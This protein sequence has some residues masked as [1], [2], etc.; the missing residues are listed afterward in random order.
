MLPISKSRGSAML[1]AL[2][3]MLVLTIAAA[4]VLR[5]ANARFRSTVQDASWQESIYSAEAGVDIAVAALRDNT[6]TGWQDGSGASATGAPPASSA[7]PPAA[8]EIRVW[9]GTLGHTAGQGGQRSAVLVQID[10]PAAL[11]DG[12]GQWYRVRST[13]VAELPG[14][15]VPGYSPALFF[16]SGARLSSQKQLHRYAFTKDYSAGLIA[17]RGQAIRKVEA[18][19]KPTVR[20]LW[21]RPFTLRNKIDMSGGGWI[22]SF[23]SADSTK[24]TNGLYDVTKRQSNGDIGTLNS[25][26]SDLRDTFVYGNLEYTGPLVANTTNVQGTITSPFVETIKPVAAP[27]WTTFNAAP[28]Q[29]KSTMT[30]TGGPA[31]APARYK[32]S[33]LTIGGGKSLT[34]APHVSGQESYVEVWVTGKMTT[35]GSGYI[36]QLSGV[37]V[38]YYVEGDITVSGSAFNNRDNIAL[39]LQIYGITPASGTKK[40]TVSGDGTFIGL[41]NAPDFDITVS[42]QADLSGSFIGNTVNISGGASVHYDEALGRIGST[43]S[44]KFTIASWAE[45]TY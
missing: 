33:E 16:E 19:V 35:S 43:S 1:M 4:E 14:V 21:T 12:S 40:L 6:W 24:S 29:I 17:G 37:H 13:G 26:S 25:T 15:R 39:N 28:S 11:S 3:A 10:A 7:S 5:M 18:I 2:A 9:K 27:T 32:V 44:E 34:W 30:L 42:G 8:T 22:D 38:T 36:D 31:G 41:V 23:D 20:G 45:E